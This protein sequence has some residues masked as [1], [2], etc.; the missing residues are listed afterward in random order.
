MST[1]PLRI[2]SLLPSTTEIVGALGLAQHLVGVSH[3]CDVCP[4]A[5]GLEEIIRAGCARV[6]VS[7]IDPS[8]LSQGTIDGRVKE[9]VRESL[10]L[11]SLRE[12]L[13]RIASPTVV[14][15]QALCD[16]CA[17]A[18]DDVSATCTR[19]GASLPSAPKVHSFEP[20]TLQQV[21]ASFEAV[22]A[23]CGVPDRG[24]ALR[25]EFESR[26]AAV[27]RASAS[28]A[29]A[30]P[31]AGAAAPTLMLLEWLDPPFD[32]GSWVPDLIDAAGAVPAPRRTASGLK[33]RGLSW[34][35]VRASD[36]DVVVVACCGFDLGRNIADALG[37]AGAP[38]ASLRAWKLGRVFA[39]D[40]NRYFARPSPSLAGG[41]A[42]LARVVWGAAAA[43]PFTPPEGE[44][45]LCLAP[46][47][48]ADA[49]PKPA[50]IPEG[51]DL[52]DLGRPAASSG[53]GGT[54]AST[55]AALHERACAAGELF[56]TD[57]ISGLSVMTRV[58]HERRGR[59]CGSGCRHCPFAHSGVAP[60]ARTAKIQVGAWLSFRLS[61]VLASRRRFR[62]R[63]QRSS[64]R[65]PLA[66]SARAPTAAA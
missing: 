5:A 41:A 28:A 8:I 14:L 58:A 60:A 37:V 27:R 50:A 25:A 4:D 63:S 43:L 24:A 3:E 26:I 15:T 20:E 12:D 13:L 35:D 9:S 2:V 59:C 40:G 18:A 19:L 21:G 65:A 31:P 1:P 17:P 32:G 62:R 7:D 48:A 49:L 23:A 61:T 57:P 44:G 51:A 29:A 10:S 45:W 53:G 36:P 6:T 52:E 30:A 16:V 64:S 34:D 56:Y 22:A 39:A 54:T 66:G 55:E 38:L 33:S 47:A 46:P 42:L 11:Y